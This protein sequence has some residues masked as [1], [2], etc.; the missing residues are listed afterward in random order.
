MTYKSNSIFTLDGHTGDWLVNLGDLRLA[1]QENGS[2]KI[3]GVTRSVYTGPSGAADDGVGAHLNMY[4]IVST[5][6]TPRALQ[7]LVGA[8]FDT[9]KQARAA[10]LDALFSSGPAAEK[11]AEN[12]QLL[13]ARGYPANVSGSARKAALKAIRSAR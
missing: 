2:V 1:E 11:R 9:M 7:P 8:K 4:K 10:V 5:G 13:M 12:N 3:E 6:N